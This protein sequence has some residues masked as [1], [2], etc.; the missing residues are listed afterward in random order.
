MTPMPPRR[1]M[2]WLAIPVLWCLLPAG[3]VTVAADPLAVA[4]GA[5][6]RVAGT[7]LPAADSV[8]GLPA[9]PA[10]ESAAQSGVAGCAAWTDRCVVCERR[11]EGRVSCSN[12]GIA[13]QPQAVQCVRGETAQEQKPPDR[14][15]EEN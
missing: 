3:S 4:S 1:A 14:K 11:S 13:C 9:T 7:A 15:K 6:S 2:A 10:P 8:P 12:I 5:A